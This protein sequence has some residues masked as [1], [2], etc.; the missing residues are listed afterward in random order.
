MSL[1]NR[2]LKLFVSGDYSELHWYQ[3]R[4]ELLEKPRAARNVVGAFGVKLSRALKRLKR[5]GILDQ[6]NKGHQNITYSLTENYRENLEKKYAGTIR[7]VV[8]SMFL[9]VYEPDDSYEQVKRKARRQWM[10]YFD[11]DKEPELR[12]DFEEM[13]KREK[14][15]HE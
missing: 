12:R 1:E 13:K 5:D 14:Q 8:R 9:G 6:H 7:S 10:E 15:T 2:I 4:N 3:I 11:R